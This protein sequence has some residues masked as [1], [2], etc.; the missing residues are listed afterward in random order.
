[1][2]V[3]DFH[4]EWTGSTLHLEHSVK[5]LVAHV[6]FDVLW[7]KHRWESNSSYSPGV[8]KLSGLPLQATLAGE[9]MG[10]K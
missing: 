1:V 9:Q 10:I 7:L 6:D 8:L 2:K 3:F 5:F 4:C